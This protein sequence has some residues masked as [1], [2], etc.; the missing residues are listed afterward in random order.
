MK[1]SD[2]VVGAFLFLLALAIF[3]YIRNFP[4]M[5][6]QKFGPA[7]F[8]AIIAGGFSVAGILLIVSGMR[9]KKPLFVISPWLRSPALVVNFLLTCAGLVFYVLAAEPLGF[10]P[11]AFIL[12]MALFLKLAVR[13]FTAVAVTL[14][15]VVVVHFAFYKLLRVP[16][17]WGVLQGV[18]W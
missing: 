14:A 6:G 15:T 1:V 11:T 5:P 12:L 18:A 7:L 17:P 2:A 8:P 10:I 13:P 4:P 9:Q 3:F 16:L